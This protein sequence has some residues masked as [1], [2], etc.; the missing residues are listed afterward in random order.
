LG[1]MGSARINAPSQQERPSTG[2]SVRGNFSNPRSRTL[3]QSNNT[4]IPSDF[5]VSPESEIVPG[6]TVLHLKFGEGKITS[7]EGSKDN[8]VA[9]IQFKND[10]MAERRIVLKFAKLQVLS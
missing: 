2:A 5:K 3:N 8:K 6:A 4:V 9:T 10:D 1:G 7:V